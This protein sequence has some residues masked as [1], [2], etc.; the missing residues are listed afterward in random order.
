MGDPVEDQKGDGRGGQCGRSSGPEGELIEG[1]V[2]RRCICE[3]H[4]FEHDVTE[5]A[6]MTRVIG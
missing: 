4:F 3:Q 2:T 6:C 5:A 1:K